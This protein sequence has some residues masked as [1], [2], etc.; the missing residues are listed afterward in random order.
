MWKSIV[1]LVTILIFQHFGI[2]IFRQFIILIF[3]RPRVSSVQNFILSAF[4]D[5]AFNRPAEL[6]GGARKWQQH[7]G[8]MISVRIETF[9]YRIEEKRTVECVSIAALIGIVN[10]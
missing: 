8:I 9:G 6:K 2:P 1:L 4:R 5:L 7:I 3:Q 10:C